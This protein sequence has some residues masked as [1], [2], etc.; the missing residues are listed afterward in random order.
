MKVSSIKRHKR[1]NFFQNA[2]KEFVNCGRKIHKPGIHRHLWTKN[3]NN[4]CEFF[5]NE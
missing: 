2:Q 4:K 5:V 1:W 3:H